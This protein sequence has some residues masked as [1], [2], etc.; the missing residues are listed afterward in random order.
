M[1]HFNLNV[2]N[3]WD[4][5]E[6]RQFPVQQKFQKDNRAVLKLR[7]VIAKITFTVINFIKAKIIRRNGF[8]LASYLGRKLQYPG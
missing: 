5:I 7:P 1:T 6:L 8:S 4:K 3:P 2:L